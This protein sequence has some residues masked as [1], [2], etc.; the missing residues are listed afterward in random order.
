MRTAIFRYRYLLWQ[1]VQRE[2]ALKYRGSALGALWSVLTPIAMLLM[3]SFVFGTI[4]QA[5]W[6]GREDMSQ[7]E[8]A[9]SLFI[10]LSVFWYFSEIFVKA[11]V[12]FT[13]VPNYVK[14]VVF[15]LGLLPLVSVAASLFQLLIYLIIVLGAM[16]LFGIP[17]SKRV[18]LV[19]F[20]IGITIPLV[21]GLSFFIGSVGVYVRDVSAIVSVVVSALMFLSPVFYPLSSV[22]EGVRW[23]FELNPLTLIIEQ[24]R[25]ALLFGETPSYVGLVIYILVSLLTLLGGYKFF[26]LTRKGFSDV[27]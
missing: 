17:I 8:F 6:P 21:T 27:V 26:R 20:Y 3:F 5:K 23:L 11:P 1:L 19:P 10:G 16:L 18:L 7:V 22:P 2:I 13:S 12:I 9:L 24:M 14:K 4:L 25:A 15:P